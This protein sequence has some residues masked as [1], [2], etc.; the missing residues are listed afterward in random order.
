MFF[1]LEHFLRHLMKLGHKNNEKYLH[2]EERRL[3]YVACTRAKKNLF[4]LS[5]NFSFSRFSSESFSYSEPSRF[6]TEIKPFDK[7]TEHY[8]FLCNLEIEIEIFLNLGK[9]IQ[10]EIW[11]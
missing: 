2:A 8:Q 4:L 9:K 3:F 6:I 1:F 11:N 5:P 7:L 10:N